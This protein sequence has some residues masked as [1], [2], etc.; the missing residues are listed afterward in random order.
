M[1]HSVL[2]GWAVFIFECLFHT[3]VKYF[4]YNPCL[5]KT[6]GLGVTLANVSLDAVELAYQKGGPGM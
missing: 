6:P 4:Q 2:I 5:E 1:V 3:V